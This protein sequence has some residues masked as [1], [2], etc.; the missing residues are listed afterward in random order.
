MKIPRLLLANIMHDADRALKM[1]ESRDILVVSAWCAIIDEAQSLPL[2]EM[3]VQETL[4]CP[5]KANSSLR[6]C[7]KRVVVLQVRTEDH[8]TRI[9]AVGPS[10]VGDCS[11]AGVKREELIGGSKSNS[12]GVKVYNLSV[13]SLSPE[14]DL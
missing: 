1:P 14:F 11:K 9:K 3:H 10:Y 8:D 2:P 13:L 12:I 6:E 5:V 7:K 4:I